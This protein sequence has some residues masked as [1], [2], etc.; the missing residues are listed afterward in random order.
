VTSL[1]KIIPRLEKELEYALSKIKSPRKGMEGVDSVS[2]V[3]STKDSYG[4]RDSL[5]VEPG[6]TV[7]A[8]IEKDMSCKDGWNIYFTGSEDEISTM[9]YWSGQAKPRNDNV[10]TT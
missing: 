3:V 1:S 10:K 4:Y 5:G 9:A 2:Y 8:V 6:E 7:I